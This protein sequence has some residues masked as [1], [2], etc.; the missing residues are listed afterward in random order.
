MSPSS[1]LTARG[2]QAL[3]QEILC[4]RRLRLVQFAGFA[5]GVDFE[6]L[7]TDSALVVE[8]A[9]RLLES[10]FRDPDG[11]AH[12]GERECEERGDQSHV[13]APATAPS[14]VKLYGGSGP[15]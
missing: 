6:Q 1:P 3:Q 7:G 5:R 8:L 13:R 11:A 9:L 15:T 10:P 4:R 14:P 12:G 2:N